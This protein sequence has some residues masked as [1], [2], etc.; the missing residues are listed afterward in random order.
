MKGN[1]EMFGSIFIGIVGILVLSVVI[2]DRI[3]QF[4]NPEFHA[5]I[6]LDYDKKQ[7]E[8][9]QILDAITIGLPPFDKRDDHKKTSAQSISITYHYHNPK[10]GDIETLLANIQKIADDVELS[11]HDTAKH[12]FYR[13]LCVGENAISVGDYNF[14]DL[15]HVRLYVSFYKYDDCRRLVY[16]NK[17]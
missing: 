8:L 1:K 3:D 5:P 10:A 16:K 17:Y 14:D 2:Y 11:E 7:A 9:Q 4:K 13:R 12:S 15:Y 6:T